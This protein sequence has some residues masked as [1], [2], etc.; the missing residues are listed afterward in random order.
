[1]IIENNR[2]HYPDIDDL[3]YSKILELSKRRDNYVKRK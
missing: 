1:M 2:K 3:S